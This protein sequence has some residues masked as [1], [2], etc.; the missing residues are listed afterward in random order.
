MT[1]NEPMP[2]RDEVDPLFDG[3]AERP[4]SELTMAERLDWIWQG[5]VLLNLGRQQRET[6]RRVSTARRRV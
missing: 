6:K 1:P 4:F 3:H 2:R 5:M